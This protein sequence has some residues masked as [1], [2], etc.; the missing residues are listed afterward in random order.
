MNIRDTIVKHAEEW[1]SGGMLISTLEKD[2]GK[3]SDPD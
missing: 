3:A 1:S 2:T